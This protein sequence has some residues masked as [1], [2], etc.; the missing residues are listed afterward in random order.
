MI[1][2]KIPRVKGIVAILASVFVPQKDIASRKGR[3]M[4]A[5]R[6]IFIQ[7]NDAR[8]RDFQIGSSNLNILV[9]IHHGNLPTKDR[10]DS[11]LPMTNTQRQIGHGL[12]IGSFVCII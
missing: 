7:S 12:N 1:N 10:L 3:G 8:K 9:D 4:V 2:R 11:L 6:N 5:L